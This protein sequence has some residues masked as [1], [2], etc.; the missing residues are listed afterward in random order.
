MLRREKLG[1]AEGLFVFACVTALFGYGVVVGR[2]QVF[3]F[4][5]L[6]FARTSLVQVFEER[7]SLLSTRPTEFLNPIRYPGNGVTRYDRH[8]AAPGLTLI[9]SFFEGGPQIRLV[10]A[11][12]SVVRRWPVRFYDLFPRPDHI[13]PEASVPQTNWNAEIHGA[14]ALPDG[15]VVFNFSY[16][17]TAKLD[18]CGRVQWTL[19]HMTHHAV[20]SAADGTLLI[21]SSRYVP[22][23]SRFPSLHP[24]YREDTVLR[25]SQSGQV[26][27]EIS[28]PDV[29][30]RNNYQGVLFQRGAT[31]DL[32]HVNDVE[33][34]SPDLAGRFPMFA[35]GDLMVSMRFGSK[36]LVMD[37]KGLRMKWYQSGPWRGQHDPDF[38]P[39]G[40]IL[41][42]NNN[43][44]GTETGS[45]FGG[46]NIMEVDPVSREVTFRY[47]T[48]D[49]QRMY[50]PEQGSHQEL[51]GGNLLIVESRTGRAFEV[52]PDGAI[53]WE[54]INRY[55]DTAVATITGAT[56]HP[57]DYFAVSDWS[58]G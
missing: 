29:L 46:G 47:G 38:L 44:D 2:Y 9:T 10:R 22:E 14:L 17:G 31:G 36:I 1:F 57:E 54:F 53:V 52:E 55:D 49:G 7:E 27:S 23:S 3:P 12:G 18:R 56:R 43:A 24:P 15:S 42:Y 16:F 11:D 26:L 40:K 20:S 32:T 51:P 35:P 37:R 45:I 33:E 34:L 4:S 21:P 50:A 8:R 48:A 28:I 58:C 41:V 6:Q 25:V 19:P 30:Y 13:R 5:A 39:N